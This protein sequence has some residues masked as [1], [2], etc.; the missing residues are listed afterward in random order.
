MNRQSIAS[1]ISRRDISFDDNKAGYF[2]MAHLSN[3]A[4]LM[5]F[6]GS[7]ATGPKTPEKEKHDRKS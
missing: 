5:K 6:G 4:H 1:V 3:H 2:Y 7:E